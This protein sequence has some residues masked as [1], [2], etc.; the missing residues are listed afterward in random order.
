MMVF[1][2]ESKDSTPIFVGQY[3]FNNDKSTESVFGW[4]DSGPLHNPKAECWEIRSNSTGLTQMTSSN[5]WVE[6]GDLIF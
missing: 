4:F 5:N 3:N 6:S 2:R 1:R